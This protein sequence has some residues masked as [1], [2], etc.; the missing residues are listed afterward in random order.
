[1]NHTEIFELTESL[2]GNR[3]TIESLNKQLSKTFNCDADV[4]EYEREECVKQDLPTLDDQLIVSIENKDGKTEYF[5][6]DLYYIKDKANRYYITEV[7]F[8]YH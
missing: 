4:S 8:N 6:L 5:D 1:M 3:Y 7:C 2:V